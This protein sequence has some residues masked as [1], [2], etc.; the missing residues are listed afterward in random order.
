MISSTHSTIDAFE[1]ELNESD[2]ELDF[3]EG[4]DD[5]SN[6][7]R[8]TVIQDSDKNES[9]SSGN[10]GVSVLPTKVKQFLE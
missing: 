7:D 9:R 5:H 6:V 10:N 3:D 8:S 4:L 1:D 2:V